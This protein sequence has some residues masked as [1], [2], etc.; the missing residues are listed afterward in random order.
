MVPFP[1]NLIPLIDDDSYVNLPKLV[2]QSENILIHQVKRDD[3]F[4]KAC[5]YF[6]Y[7]SQGKS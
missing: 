7:N 2:E 4:L 3:W 1:V 5:N 6:I